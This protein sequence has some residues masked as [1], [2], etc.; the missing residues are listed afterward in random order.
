MD[1]YTY[2][3][4]YGKIKIIKDN[5]IYRISDVVKLS[6]SNKTNKNA[7]CNIILQEDLYKTTI[8]HKYLQKLQK[9]KICNT[10]TKH[11]LI[12]ETALECDTILNTENYGNDYL[13]IHLRAGDNYKVFG[14]GNEKLYNSLTN[15][16]KTFIE[17][18]E[19]IKKVIIVTAL[20][21]GHNPDSKIYKN[22]KYCYTEE[23][24]KLNI[25]II[26]KFVNNLKN[27]LPQSIS[28]N[29]ISSTNCDID[30]LTLIKA[31]NI[32]VTKGGFSQLVKKINYLYNNKT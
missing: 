20:H 27:I 13:L 5:E 29:F 22:K 8:L 9:I 28:I 2:D 6:N 25:E 19:N 17:K 23:N 21:Y 15:E 3:D 14:L 32:I 10:N 24:H 26:E 11:N 16:S 7:I 1:L 12:M 18:N 4:I 31:K 30:F